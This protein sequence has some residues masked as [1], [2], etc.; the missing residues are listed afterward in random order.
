MAAFPQAK[1]LIA[2]ATDGSPLAPS[3]REYR[4]G[5]LPTGRQFTL[6]TAI[7]E[8]TC[9]TDFSF[10]TIVAIAV[11]TQRHEPAGTIC[12]ANSAVTQKLCGSRP[13]ACLVKVH[14][15]PKGEPWPQI[16]LMRCAQT[17]VRL[18]II[19]DG[20]VIFARSIAASISR[21]F[22]PQPVQHANHV[23]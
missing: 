20:R 4:Q 17:N 8:L 14:L 22:Y 1:P 21:R 3:S 9:G 18:A 10:R 2:T 6:L 16:L 13:Y 11:P 5:R 15:P 12:L 19:S 23:K 7:Q